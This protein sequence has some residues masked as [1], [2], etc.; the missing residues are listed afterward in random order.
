[1]VVRFHS[2]L[3]EGIEFLRSIDL[4]M[5][6]IRQW[7]CEVEVLGCRWGIAVCHDWQ[8]RIDG[9]LSRGGLGDQTI[10]N[11]IL[12]TARTERLGLTVQ[13]AIKTMEAL[14]EKMPRLSCQVK[15]R[16]LGMISS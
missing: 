4:D 6:D 5:G 3:Y 7:I 2:R 1:M 14:G 13:Q 11:S 9:M 8:G 12:T 15:I 10:E 16:S